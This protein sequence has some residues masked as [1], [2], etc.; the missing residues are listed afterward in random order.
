MACLGARTTD[1]CTSMFVAPCS[2]AQYVFGRFL[3]RSHK[4]AA[5][6]PHPSYAT[7]QSLITGLLFSLCVVILGHMF[8]IGAA[9]G[10]LSLL[11]LARLLVGFGTGTLVL[12]RTF[13]GDH[14]PLSK[15]SRFMAWL[16]VEQFIGFAFTPGLGSL[17]LDS[18][19]GKLHITTFNF[20][21]YLLALLTLITFVGLCL[22][23]RWLRKREDAFQQQLAR[24]REQSRLMDDNNLSSAMVPPLTDGSA[25]H[26]PVASSVA[27]PSPTSAQDA[28][29]SSSTTAALLPSASAV[30]ARDN[31]LLWVL[32]FGNLVIRGSLS[33]AE[34]FGSL[35][36]FIVISPGEADQVSDSATF[37][38][39]LGVGGV[40]VF[41]LVEYLVK[42]FTT[43]WVLI[44]SLL[45]AMLGYA[46]VM[47]FDGDLHRHRFVA[48]M[49]FVWSISSPIAQTTIA[50]QLSAELAARHQAAAAAADAQGANSVIVT[51]SQALWMGHLTAAGS[52]GRILFPLLGGALY[53]PGNS[54]GVML[55]CLLAHALVFA[56]Y[57]WLHRR[58]MRADIKKQLSRILAQCNQHELAFRLLSRNADH[59]LPGRGE[60]AE[61][62]LTVLHDDADADTGQL[63]SLPPLAQPSW[64][65]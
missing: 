12:A 28:R 48:G 16:G 50:S 49:L 51:P 47:D 31:T 9:A 27:L 13:V 38:F 63:H 3:S 39:A 58:E 26:A 46:L 65:A 34:T 41:L 59:Q 2:C 24:L 19:I 61:V 60:G 30:V 21:S 20:G 23:K 36:Y 40:A 4:H 7:H 43:R 33:I 15:K 32:V 56:S 6:S 45:L 53:Q 37:F 29:P 18:Y 57:T 11:L 25:S 54:G 62:A 1:S 14:V 5:R 42:W 8:Y 22:V 35:I 17:T 52:V 64:H 55:L 44:L 10:G